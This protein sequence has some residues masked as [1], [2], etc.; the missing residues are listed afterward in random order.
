MRLFI[1]IPLTPDARRA[2]E[3]VAARLAAHTD[4][5]F[6]AAGNYHITLAFL[7][8]Y[9]PEQVADVEQAMIACRSFPPTALCL[10]RLGFFG[11]QENAI[12][13][14]GVGGGKALIPLSE[15]LRSELTRRGLSFDPKPMAPHITLARHFPATDRLLETPVPRSAWVA[16]R[17][18]LYH[19]HRIADELVYEPIREVFF[20]ADSNATV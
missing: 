11:R 12:L 14:C 3:S 20:D 5:R 9:A 13:Y 17:M 8:E 7:G 1:G 2:A 4:V 19:S 10:D 18:I 15:Y 6:V 16:D